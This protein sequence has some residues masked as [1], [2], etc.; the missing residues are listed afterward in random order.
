MGAGH[1]LLQ[2]LL[3]YCKIDVDKKKTISNKY[4]IKSL[5]TLAIFQNGKILW[6]DTGMKT[7]NELLNITSQFIKKS[8]QSSVGEIEASVEKTSW[9]GRLFK[10]S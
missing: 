3:I 4:K 9:F 5:P 6:R 7:K 1:K 2:A 8:P 10:K